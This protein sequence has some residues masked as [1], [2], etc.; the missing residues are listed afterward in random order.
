MGETGHAG[1][2]RRPPR[3]WRRPAED[4]LA[5]QIC[6]YTHFTERDGRRFAWILAGQVAGRGPDSEPLVRSPRPLG[7]L[8][9][10]VLAEARH[11]Y[12]GRFDVGRE[13]SD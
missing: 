2:G 7:V 5:R 6:R 12:H 9:D 10:R 1:G 8:G 11:R 13:S 4:W 3:W